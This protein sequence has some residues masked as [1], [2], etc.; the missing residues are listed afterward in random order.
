MASYLQMPNVN[1]AFLLPLVFT[2]QEIADRFARA[3]L[4]GEN[5]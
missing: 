3:F 5:L 2:N 4:F 1:L